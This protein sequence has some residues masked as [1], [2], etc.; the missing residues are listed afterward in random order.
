VAA[1]PKTSGHERTSARFS[2]ANLVDF[3]LEYASI[4]P[5]HASQRFLFETGIRVNRRRDGTG[6][7]SAI[8]VRK[9]RLGRRGKERLGD[10][11]GRNHQRVA[12]NARASCSRI[13][14][15]CSAFGRAR[16]DGSAQRQVRI[17][18]PRAPRLPEEAL[19]DDGVSGGQRERLELAE[20]V[21]V[22]GAGAIVVYH[23]DRF[24]RNLAGTIAYLRPP[25]RVHR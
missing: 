22:T 8:L 10:V 11:V 3:V 15:G 21:R 16:P 20:R 6:I 1:Q 5:S 23:V 19:V 14:H 25:R 7:L 24:A 4:G 2:S 17:R 9:I 12:Y 13:W 18:G